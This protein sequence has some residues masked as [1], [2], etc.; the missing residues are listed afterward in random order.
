MLRAEGLPALTLRAFARRVGV[1]HM[2]P[3]PH[4]GDLSKLV[5]KLAAVGYRAFGERLRA[6]QE[7]PGARS[8]PNATAHAYFAFARDE[9]AMFLLMFRSE[10]PDFTRPALVD[11]VQEASRRLMRSV[12]ASGTPPPD[13][14]DFA[15]I[16]RAIGRWS[17][18]HGFA[19][20]L[21]DGRLDGILASPDCNGDVDALLDGA[22]AT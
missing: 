15:I 13:I 6:A 14:G 5:S 20:L 3:A 22:L 19:M 8:V 18:V 1:S 2:A 9:P 21:I 11:A 16:G 7:S 17:V 4:F 12:D 10:R